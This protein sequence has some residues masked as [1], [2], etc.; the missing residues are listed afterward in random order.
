MERDIGR[1]PALFIFRHIKKEFENIQLFDF[2]QKTRKIIF[3]KKSC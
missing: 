1:Y 3:L 2:K